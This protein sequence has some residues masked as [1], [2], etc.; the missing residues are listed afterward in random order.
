MT[1]SMLDEP[2]EISVP[3]IRVKQPIGEFYVASMSWRTLR[4]ITLVDVRRLATEKREVETYLGIQRPLIK[5]RVEEIK[6][7]VTNSDACFP[8]AVIL[9]IEG[10]CAEFDESQSLLNLHSVE[11]DD[12]D[13]VRSTKI[14]K[15]LDGQHR[16]EGLRDFAGPE[17]DINVS[18]FID[19]DI[20]S[21][22]YLFSTVNLQQTKV[23]RSLVYDLFD[24]SQARSPQ[25][26]AHN[27]AVAL[28]ALE[29]GPF[30]QRIKRLGTATPG[31]KNETLTQAAF[32]E[33]LLPFM[34][35]NMIRDRDL[36]LRGKRPPKVSE[37]EAVKMIF[38][39]MFLDEEDIKIADVVNNFFAAVAEKWP[40]AWAAV[41]GLM[42]GKTNG[43]TAMMRLLP[44]IYRRLVKSGDVPR[45][46][47]FR[48]FLEKSQLLEDDFTIENFKPGTSG[49]AGLFKQLREQLGI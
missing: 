18:I 41:D 7:Y 10:R 42:L 34:T 13:G 16:I 31:R 11:G 3:C 1:D 4:E 23:N 29:G 44:P 25:K 24:Y 19:M 35:S 22:A 38:R 43:F 27:V 37:D 45:R 48:S 47:D 40:R 14:A 9:A 12:D 46:Q 33:A 21:Q 20:E 15:V 2:F 32:V 8:T 6:Q 5:S 17:F 30:F 49:Q 26:T 36:Y 39:R 28:D